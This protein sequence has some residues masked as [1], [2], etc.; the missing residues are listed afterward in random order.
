MLLLVFKSLLWACIHE[1]TKCS[2]TDNV[3]LGVDNAS[4]ATIVKGSL[5]HGH[6]RLA[7]LL[8]RAAEIVR[9]KGQDGDATFVVTYA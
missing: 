8:A 9:L 4:I 3:L 2:L 5:V 1:Y 6:L 7:E